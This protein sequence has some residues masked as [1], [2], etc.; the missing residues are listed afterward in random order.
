MGVRLAS[1]GLALLEFSPPGSGKSSHSASRR[2][3]RRQLGT[4]TGRGSYTCLPAFSSST[5][6][7]T[8]RPGCGS[9]ALVTG[10]RRVT[11]ARALHS[12]VFYTGSYARGVVG[13]RPT[14]HLVD[15][16]TCYSCGCGL[17][18]QLAVQRFWIVVSGS[19]VSLQVGSRHGRT[20]GTRSG[21]RM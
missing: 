13:L 2:Q 19:K 18:F 7:V 11:T 16:C 17:V 1:K 14:R 8:L 9:T 12:W 21:F 5:P 15:A 20:F 10:T 4:T 6:R 3:M